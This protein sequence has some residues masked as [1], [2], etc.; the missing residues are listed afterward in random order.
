MTFWAYYWGSRDFKG[1]IPLCILHIQ[2]QLTDT[3]SATPARD[4]TFFNKVSK[5]EWSSG[6]TNAPTIKQER[7]Y[8]YKAFKTVSLQVF[9]ASGVFLTYAGGDFQPLETYFLKQCFYCNL[10]KVKQLQD[11]QNLA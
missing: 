1:Q 9:E 11:L 2:V 10:F 4:D 7:R 8:R 5:F 6:Q 3:D